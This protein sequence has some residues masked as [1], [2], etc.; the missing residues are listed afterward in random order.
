M[1]G[2]SGPPHV[3]EN[4]FAGCFLILVEAGAPGMPQTVSLWM[5]QSQ[6]N[7]VVPSTW[8]PTI[9]S[10]PETIAFVPLE[11]ILA[12]YAAPPHIA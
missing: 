10:T 5:V 11:L 4:T 1:G 9:S 3:M 12:N 6:S 7:L 8:P 2:F